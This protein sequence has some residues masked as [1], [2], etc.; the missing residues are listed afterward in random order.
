MSDLAAI[1]RLKKEQQQ[2][3]AWHYAVLA[4]DGPLALER[5]IDVRSTLKSLTDLHAHFAMHVKDAVRPSAS[6][7]ASMEQAFRAL[8]PEAILAVLNARTQ[9]RRGGGG[10]R[11]PSLPAETSL[12]A[13]GAKRKAARQRHPQGGDAESGDDQPLSP[14]EEEVSNTP[15]SSDGE[16]Q[17]DDRQRA[18]EVQGAAVKRAKTGR[19]STRASSPVVVYRERCPGG[20]GAAHDADDL[21]KFC[22]HCG[23]AWASRRPTAAVGSS[24][25]PTQPQVW[26]KASSFQSKALSALTPRPDLRSIQLGNLPEAVIK[27]AR[28][29][30][31]HYT[32]AD[33]MQPSATEGSSSSVLVD[34]RTF[35]LTRT[36]SGTLRSS[37]GAEATCAR[38]A[39]ARK[40][41]IA[42]YTDI[43][44]VFF[45]TLIGIIYV[46]RPDICEQLYSL[47]ALAQDITR[48]HGFRVALAYVDTIRLHF[49]SSGG[50][51]GGVHVLN[52]ESTF[53][54]GR[55]EQTV[56]NA[57]LHAF[58][59][60]KSAAPADGAKR[61]GNGGAGGTGVGGS[62]NV[63]HDFNR[64][65]CTRPRCRF[66]HQCSSC[67]TEGHSATQCPASRGASGQPPSSTAPA[68]PA[69]AAAQS[70]KGKK[71]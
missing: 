27:K 30:Q 26:G 70:G 46:G 58:P 49:W 44:E 22:N 6:G 60:Q 53:D 20:C 14:A 57:S 62:G 13:R 32:L 59:P 3:L 42:S 54:M 63:C 68:A 50:G 41:S 7:L 16:D 66:S 71:K 5:T 18:V 28:E 40:R 4:K 67:G 23:T 8:T 56:L 64:G 25:P 69:A 15:S 61:G 10:R 34:E 2:A 12:K 19:P 31:Q 45:Y 55:F 48:A 65:A 33:L 43:A 47:L 11:G 21:P 38:T 37:S 1:S 51:K 39:A 29:G 24:S 35:V 52:I 17:E 9:R 36:E